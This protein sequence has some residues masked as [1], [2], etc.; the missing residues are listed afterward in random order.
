[1]P[2]W[3]RKKPEVEEVKEPTKEN[4]KE[5]FGM[6]DVPDI[7]EK[8]AKAIQDKIESTITGKPPK[9]EGVAM[10][11]A[12]TPNYVPNYSTVNLQALGFLA[13]Q[14][15]FIG[16]GNMELLAQH[17]I[18]VRACGLRVNDATKRWYELSIGDGTELDA[19]QIKEIE[20]MDKKY[21]LKENMREGVFF[22][23]VFG[24]RHILFKHTNPDFDYEAQFNP[25]SWG[26][27]EYAGMA[28]IDPSWMQPA[29]DKNDLSDPTRIGFYDPTYWVVNGK[30][31]HK[32]HFV[33]LRGE[34]VADR[35]KPTYRYGGISKVQ[36][37]YERAYAAERSANEGPQLLMT[38][39][40]VNRFVDM[41]KAQA[42]KPKFNESLVNMASY[43]DNYGV[44]VLGKDENITQLDTTLSDVDSVITK[45]YEIVCAIFGDPVSKIMGSGHGGLGTGE[46]DEDYYISNVEQLQGDELE[47]I[48]NAHYARLIP[49]EIKP[50]FNVEPEIELNWRPLKVMSAK[51]VAEVNN[52]NANTDTLLYNLHS[53]DSV[54]VG[55][56]LQADKQ[57]GYSG[58]E[59]SEIKEVEEPDF[60]DCGDSNN[61][62]ETDQDE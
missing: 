50:R 27:G 11:S 60:G 1:M 19:K 42:N 36:M 25:D 54:D 38:K 29:F 40:L 56:R 16:Y 32:S 17:W 8:R 35:L 33:I 7:T 45:Q 22:N 15:A 14:G 41:V 48:A 37:A 28:Q 52:I 12:C 21:N 23:N 10:D 18:M 20:K 47:D 61:D 43:R 53:I 5:S 62:K 9:V 59:V 3:K 2:F 30:K 46:T 44:N 51:E 55:K 26:P 31:Y 39:R 34:L 58:I 13:G 6:F 49:T 24:V 57:S 4:P